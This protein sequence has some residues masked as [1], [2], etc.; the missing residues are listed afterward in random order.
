MHFADVMDRVAQ[1]IRDIAP[2][3]S[4]ERYSALGVDV[5][6]GYARIVDPWH[7]EITA[8][9]WCQAS[10]PS[11]PARSSWPPA[12]RP[13][14]HHCR[15]WSEVGVLTSDTLWQLREL[16]R[17]LVVLGGGPIGCELAQA[18]ARLGSVV[19]QIEQQPRILVREKTTMWPRSRPLPCTLMA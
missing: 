18:F 14:Y 5:R 16:P 6:Q 3:D 9:G 17:R 1:V 15:A 19:T 10:R 12:L 4:I 11:R 8:A 2:H 13:S 7:V